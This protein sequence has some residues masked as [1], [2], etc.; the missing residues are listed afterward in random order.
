MTSTRRSFWH[1]F[2]ELLA[3]W[4]E[5]RVLAL[6]YLVAYPYLRRNVQR[7]MV[8][9]IAMISH[10][11]PRDY[12]EPDS[13]GQGMWQSLSQIWKEAMTR[14]WFVAVI[15]T[16]ASG[17]P[18]PD[19]YTLFL[20]KDKYRREESCSNGAHRKY[21]DEY[22]SKNLRAG[23][24]QYLIVIWQDGTFCQHHYQWR[25]DF[26]ADDGKMIYSSYSYN[27]PELSTNTRRDDGTYSG[28]TWWGCEGWGDLMLYGLLAASRHRLG[29]RVAASHQVG[30]G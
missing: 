15:E 5:G 12:H 19:Y 30:A 21:V 10:K 24:G 3:E 17:P 20:G 9:G 1:L 22:L 18:I 8:G 11:P 2:A 23:S 29:Y 6:G 13:A 25:C 28:R 4:W 26:Y 27:V 14:L 16:E 7:G